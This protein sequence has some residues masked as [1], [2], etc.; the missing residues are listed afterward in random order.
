MPPPFVVFHPRR[1]P[2]DGAS[3]PATPR[4]PPPT[5][6]PRKTA[7]SI[8]S[9]AS[10]SQPAP[11]LPADARGRFPRLRLSG[12]E[13][14]HNSMNPA[15]SSVRPNAMCGKPYNTRKVKPSG[16]S[17]SIGELPSQFGWPSNK[18]QPTESP[19]ERDDQKRQAANGAGRG[20]QRDKAVHR[21]QQQSAE[22]DARRVIYR[23]HRLGERPMAQTGRQCCDLAEQ[24]VEQKRTAHPGVARSCR[25]CG[26]AT[27]RARLRPSWPG[28][29]IRL[30]RPGR[31]R[32]RRAPPTRAPRPADTART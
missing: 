4:P 18:Q 27:R 25:R 12:H 23:D 31:T 16:R 14:P 29:S 7:Q 10:T 20:E 5:P 15:S 30:R 11:A 19:A 32:Q 1:W 28:T 9:P 3:P 6:P 21:Q 2:A 8:P 13:S 24:N 22:Q 17:K 26:T